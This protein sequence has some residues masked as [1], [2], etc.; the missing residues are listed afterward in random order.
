MKILLIYPHF[1]EKRV[2]VDEVT[3]PPLGLYYVAALCRENGHDVAVLNWHDVNRRPQ[4]IRTA[5][6]EKQPDVIGFSILN[7][8]RWGAIEIA[9]LA[10]QILPGVRI[11]FGGIGA[12]T[13]WEL[14]LTHFPHIDYVVL[15]EG[16]FAFLKL[17]QSLAEGRDQDIPKIDGLAFRSEG[18]A[19]RTACGEPIRDLDRLPDPGRHDTFQH[20]AL[21]RGCIGDCSFC[22]SPAFWGRRVRFHSPAYFVGQLERLNRRGVRHFYFSDDTFTLNPK[23]VIEVCRLILAHG[24]DFTWQA[25][26]RVDMVDEEVFYWMRRAGCIQISYGVESGSEKIRRMLGK[27]FSTAQIE[28]AFALTTRYG[29]LSRAYFIYGCP[30]ESLET[31][32]ATID[33]MHRI[34]PLSVIFYILDLFPGTALYEAYKK[35]YGV[36]DDIWL[37]RIEDILYFETDP[38]LDSDQVLA[39]GKMLRL[40]FHKGLPDFLKR[41]E[42]E[43]SEELAPLHADFLSRLAM[44]FDHGD[45][46]AIDSIPGK[47]ALAESLYRRALG[48]HADPRAYLGLGILLQKAGQHD[49][50]RKIL[51]EALRHYPE[52]EHLNICLGVSLMNMG[53]YENAMACLRPFGQSEQA[54][55]FISQCRRALSDRQAAADRGEKQQNR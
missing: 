40:A 5:L 18:K 11:V 38:E 8:N 20:V 30:G 47:T 4:D 50:S 48:F 15:G 39:F 13:L 28:R 33:L 12:T 55:R 27:N 6:M 16:E 35:K 10:R 26:S 36:G 22:G 44:T 43:E 53:Q 52:H 17:V 25:I 34:K 31:I 49:A 37:D 14:L 46:A 23:K 29:I 1:L 9:E 45:Y 2:N 24:L 54:S 51:E 42:L 32:Q 3:V 21:T 19:V 7:A 41:L